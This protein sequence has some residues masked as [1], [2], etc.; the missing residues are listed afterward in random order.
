MIAGYRRFRETEWA[1]DQERFRS[2]AANGQ[3]PHS[4]VIACSDSRVDPQMIF[5]ART[6]E[7]F[8]IRNVASVVP[9]YELDQAHHGTSAAI[10]FAVRVLEIER[11]F[12]LGHE[13]CGGISVLL[14]DAPDGR[15]DFATRWMALAKEA[16]AA[17]EVAGG[18]D[19]R[20]R[21]CEEAVV[22]LS[23]DN[24]LTFPWIA[25]AVERNTLTLHGGYFD[26]GRGELLV[27]D[28]GGAFVV[29]ES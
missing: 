20:R 25:E 17:V 22:R 16:A 13:G 28:Q 23:L 26:I 27:M 19:S 7:L 6:G 3:R 9:P 10:E 21:R 11:I 24:L 1:E 14:E 8:V 15:L 29:V 18:G 2:L 12:V 4:L 5:G